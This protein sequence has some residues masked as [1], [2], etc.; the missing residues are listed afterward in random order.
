M[1]IAKRLGLGST[2]SASKAIIDYGLPAYPRY[3]P[4]NNRRVI[5]ASEAMVLAWELTRARDYQQV[6]QK[7]REAKKRRGGEAEK[8]A[9]QLVG[10]ASTPPADD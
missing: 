6:M 7:R 4:H 1:A 8:S 2:Q 9:E 3:N 10:T 5:Y